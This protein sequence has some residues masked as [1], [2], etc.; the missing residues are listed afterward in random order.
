MTGYPRQ[1]VRGYEIREKVGAG[2]FGE[3]YRAFQ[4]TVGR[5]VAIKSILPQHANHVDFI[6]RF[7][8]E[9]QMVARLEHPHIVPLYDYWREPGNAFLVMRWLHTSLGALLE[10]EGFWSLEATARL[11]DS[12]ME[13]VRPVLETLTPDDLDKMRF[14]RRHGKDFSVMWGLLHALEHWGEHVGHLGLTRQLW[15]QGI[16]R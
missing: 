8:V 7:E 9:A 13:D 12:A 11:L 16:G 14:S 6:R 1:N 10:K 3:V 4:T 2:G 5:E 15:D